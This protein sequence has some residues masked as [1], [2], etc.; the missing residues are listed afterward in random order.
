MKFFTTI[1]AGGYAMGKN[2]DTTKR[3]NIAIDEKLHR[4]LKAKAATEGKTMS[5]YVTTLIKDAI[6]E[7]EDSEE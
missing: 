2:T 6:G 4:Q 5:E 3:L 7:D 1:R